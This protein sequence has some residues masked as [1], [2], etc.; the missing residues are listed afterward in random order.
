MKNKFFSFFLLLTFILTTGA[1]CSPTVA[2]KSI[3]PI[4]ITYWRVFDDA[5]AFADIIANYKKIHPYITVEYK[6]FRYEEYEKELLNALAEDRGP[7]IFSI[8]SAWLGE[9]QA[10]LAP[11]PP[12]LT[13]TYPVTRGTIKKETIAEVR[14]TKSL[15]LKDLKTNFVDIVSSDALLN[16]DGEERIYGL[17]LYI[18][19]MAMY[20][21]PSLFNNA[22]ISAPP[23]Y[24]DTEFQQDVK[25][26]TKQNNQGN[27]IQSGVALGGNAN[28]ERPQDIISLL[29]MQNGAVMMDNGSVLFHI[30]PAGGDQKYNPGLEA[31]RFY[32]DF[33]NPG[34][35][36][37]CWNS[38]LENSLNLFAQGSLAMMFSY[39]YNLPVIRALAPKL[40]FSIAKMPQIRGNAKQVN[41]ANYWLEGVS[42]K[43]KNINEAWDFIQFETSQEQVQSY[44][45][46]AKKPTALRTLIKTQ[47]DDLDIGVFADQVLTAQSWYH[48]KDSLA[49][50]KAMSDMIDLTIK[51]E[52]EIKQIME[53]GAS[54]VQQTVF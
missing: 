27:I 35:D 24:W 22:G 37:Y 1:G 51:N 30:I 3:K 5:D 42:A 49:A 15:T 32:T 44:L 2:P 33:S 53:Q 20:Y 8:P 11:L 12:E 47:T 48:G 43:T 25:K 34:K 17:P 14:T 4:T 36:V 50:E 31:L 29:M 40:T 38:T 9:Y 46:I 52:K 45:K 10:K 28:I 54:K 19:T 6:K 41:Y 23:Q 13:L 21:N 18:D 39:S 26:L 7:D 16:K